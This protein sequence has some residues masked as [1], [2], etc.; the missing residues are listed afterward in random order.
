MIITLL[1]LLLL[2]WSQYDNLDNILG[3]TNIYNML[4]LLFIISLVLYTKSKKN[5]VCFLNKNKKKKTTQEIYFHRSVCITAMCFSGAICTISSNIISLLC[6]IIYT[7][8]REDI[9]SNKIKIPY[10]E[11]IPI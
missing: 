4:A 10:K 3:I 8:L 6:T 9:K 2:H 1:S 5:F 11:H 7:K